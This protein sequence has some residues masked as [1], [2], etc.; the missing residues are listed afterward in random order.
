MAQNL[1]YPGK[2]ITTALA[3]AVVSG[4]LAA[5]GKMVGVANLTTAAD[6]ANVYSVEG[7]FLVPKK[8]TDDVTVGALLYLDADGKSVTTTAGT[9]YVGVAWAA[10]ANGVETVPVRLNFAAPAGDQA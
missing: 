7:V 1:K 2:S 8:K 5:I 10:A 4:Q 9:Q 6:E 3:S